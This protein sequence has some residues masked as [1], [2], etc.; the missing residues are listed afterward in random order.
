[1][2]D[3]L[4]HTVESTRR[5][6]G[7]AQSQSSDREVIQSWVKQVTVH[8]DHILLELD[9]EAGLDD[10]RIK[11]AFKGEDQRDVIPRQIGAAPH[12]LRRWRPGR[13]FRIGSRTSRTAQP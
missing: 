3:R 12:H 11:I 1:M 2:R 6:G 4:G 10:T 7:A 9:R 13:P 5:M 8:P